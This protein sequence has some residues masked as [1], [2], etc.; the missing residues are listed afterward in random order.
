MNIKAP[1]PET[2]HQELREKRKQLHGHRRKLHEQLAEV[3]E[4]FVLGEMTRPHKKQ[5]LVCELQYLLDYYKDDANWGGV[6]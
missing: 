2:A 5:A 6:A 1:K 3:C 4:E